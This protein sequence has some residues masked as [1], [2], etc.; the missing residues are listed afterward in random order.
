MREAP[1]IVVVEGLLQRGAR[2]VAHDPEAMT[3]A[4]GLF[5]DRIGYVHHNYDALAGADALVIITEWK[6]Y[7]VPN[8]QRM[9]EQMRQ[10]II[11]DGR[12]LF[13]TTR[14]RELGFE[15]TSIG[16]P[17]VRLAPGVPAR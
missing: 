6:Q 5:G 8:F 2:V 12:N 3:V 14:M 13:D 11:F 16:R 7:R 9:R 1:A 4:R 17:A 15:Y 10:P